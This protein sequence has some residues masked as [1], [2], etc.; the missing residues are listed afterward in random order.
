MPN[1]FPELTIDTARFGTDYEDNR[2]QKIVSILIVGSEYGNNRKL[3]IPSV[4]I[5]GTY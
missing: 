5:A 2:D 4:L 1:Y 3:K